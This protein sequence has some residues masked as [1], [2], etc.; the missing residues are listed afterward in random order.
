MTI[1]LVVPAVVNALLRAR[2]ATRTRAKAA[3]VK[4]TFARHNIAPSV[5]QLHFESTYGGVV[6]PDDDGLWLFGAHACLSSNAHPKL[7][8]S[9]QRTRLV[10]VAY[11]PNDVV[12]FLDAVGR[13]YAQ[14]TIEDDKPVSF[15]RDGRGIVSRIVLHDAQFAMRERRELAGAQGAAMAKKLKLKL[16]KEASVADARFFSDANGGIIVVETT[17]PRVTTVACNDAARLAVLDPPRPSK[18]APVREL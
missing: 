4:A 5:A 14:D 8:A 12:Y 17:K 9:A 6:L 18:K 15:A 3:D 2:G 7:A 16:V 1:A 10:P 13:G 11:S